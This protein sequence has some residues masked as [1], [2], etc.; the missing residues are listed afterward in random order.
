[1][2][3]IYERP[4]GKDALTLSRVGWV[5][6]FSQPNTFIRK[7]WVNDKAVNPTYATEGDFLVD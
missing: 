5:A 7:C 4:V 3:P 1:M 6:R 2:R